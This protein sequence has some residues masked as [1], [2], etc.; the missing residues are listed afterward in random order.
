MGV[1]NEYQTNCTFFL[2][3]LFQERKNEM[4]MFIMLGVRE[5]PRSTLVYL[6]LFD[7]WDTF[8]PFFSCC[9][10]QDKEYTLKQL[11]DLVSI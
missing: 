2:S 4:A 1:H 7:Y 11:L 9:V 6:F 10:T 3:Y 8:L 5:F